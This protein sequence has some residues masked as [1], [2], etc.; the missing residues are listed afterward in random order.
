MHRCKILA[1]LFKDETPETCTLVF[2]TLFVIASPFH[3][4]KKYFISF[5]I[6]NPFYPKKLVVTNQIRHT[7]EIPEIFLPRLFGH[8]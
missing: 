2:R 5:V 6:A 7:G 4:N 8:L 1:L 3:P